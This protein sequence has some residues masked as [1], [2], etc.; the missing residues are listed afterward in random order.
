MN[1]TK[2][3]RGATAALGLGRRAKSRG[4]NAGRRTLARDSMFLMAVI[5]TK[6]AMDGE[7]VPVRVRNL[8]ETG[9]MAD[10]S[11]GYEVGD[12]I[13]VD[14]RGLGAVAG[15]VAWVE[16][17]R[18]GLIFDEQVDPILARKPL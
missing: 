11:G 8:S 14:V 9:L 5:R 17:S 15:K 3:T 1:E 16:S 12:C 13:T 7:G 10:C 2:I 18:I 4:E 6:N